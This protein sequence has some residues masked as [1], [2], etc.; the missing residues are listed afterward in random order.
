MRNSMQSA[1]GEIQTA[2]IETVVGVL[3][4][5]KFSQSQITR[6][7]DP[8]GPVV[9][10]I[11]SFSNI[12][13]KPAVSAIAE[14]GYMGMNETVVMRQSADGFIQDGVESDCKNGGLCETVRRSGCQP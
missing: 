5:E 1:L 10:S 7:E 8:G 13:K 3:P 9:G 4:A 12:G 14:G 11:W 2:H 6:L